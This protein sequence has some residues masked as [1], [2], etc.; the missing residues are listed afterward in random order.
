MYDSPY[1]KPPTQRAW[2]HWLSCGLTSFLIC[3]GTGELSLRYPGFFVGWLFANVALAVWRLFRR[4]LGAVERRVLKAYVWLSPLLLL[5]TGFF[6]D[7]IVF[8]DADV[9]I[10]QYTKEAFFGGQKE[11]ELVTT[12][13]RTRYWLYEEKTSHQETIGAGASR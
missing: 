6:N 12:Y 10:H 8:R 7:D 13:Y 9:S 5:G 11:D 4:P 2:G 1:D 3:A